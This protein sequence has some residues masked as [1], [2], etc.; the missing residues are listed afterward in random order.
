MKGRVYCLHVLGHQPRIVTGT[1]GV[2]VSEGLGPPGHTREQ[3][4]SG[5]FFLTLRFY[6]RSEWVFDGRDST[7]NGI[8]SLCYKG[9]VQ[10]CLLLPRSI[11]GYLL[12]IG[13]HSVRDTGRLSGEVR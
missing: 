10:P 11:V 8:W 2:S 6:K 1:P 7:F 13:E 12:V 4:V 9:K 3:Y 5:R